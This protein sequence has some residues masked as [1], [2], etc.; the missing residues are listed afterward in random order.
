MGI[1]VRDY[2]LGLGYRG[3]G[4]R[5]DRRLAGRLPSW[6]LRRAR[7]DRPV[8]CLADSGP[9]AATLAALRHPSRLPAALL[10]G[11]WPSYRCRPEEFGDLQPTASK[12]M[13]F[14]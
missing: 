3:A 9:L 11:R 1:W 2:G 5:T 7:A 8:A 4:G 10:A 6:P 13:P 12:G 14:T